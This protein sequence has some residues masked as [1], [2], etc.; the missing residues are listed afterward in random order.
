M[1]Q[2]LNTV[3]LYL[4]GILFVFSLDSCINDDLSG[5]MTEKRVYFDYPETYTQSGINPNDITRMD[6]FIFDQDGTFLTEVTD[7]SPQ[8]GP[9]YYMTVSN[10][11]QGFYKFIAWGNLKDQYS[12]F[13]A[14]PIKGEMSVDDLEVHLNKIKDGLVTE[15]L[16]PLF[17]ATHKNENM[18]E[19]TSMGRQD[20]HLGMV[21]NTYK[22]NVEISGIDALALEENNFRV[23]ISDNNGKYKFDNDFASCEKFNYTQPCHRKDE[24]TNDIVTSLTVMRL[25]EGREPVIQIINENTDQVLTTDNLVELIL[26]ASEA[27]GVKVDF[28]RQFEFNIRYELDWT[29]PMQYIIY[30]NDWKIVRQEDGNLI[31]Y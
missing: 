19:V 14:T 1:K 31:S 17:F 22:I 21:Q 25:A 20:F 15:T 7:E 18:L 11:K 5:C 27:Q 9:D 8:M 4:L 3:Q 28:S 10:L 30:I 26:T 6:L 23:T 16:Q 29:T 13:P 24:L 12:V 2:I